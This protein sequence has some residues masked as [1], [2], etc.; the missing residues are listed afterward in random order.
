[1]VFCLALSVPRSYGQVAFSPVPLAFPQ[2]VI[3]GDPTGVNYTTLIQMI[4][5]NSATVTGKLSLLSDSGSALQGSFDGQSPQTS[6]DISLG[7]SEFRQIAVTLEGGVTVGWLAAAFSPAEVVTS[8]ILQ[9]RSG[10]SLLSEVGVDPAY[11]TVLNTDFA[12]DTDDGLNTGVALANPSTSPTYI[13]ARLWDPATGTAGASTIIALAGNGHIARFV[14]E[15]FPDALNITKTR[16]KVSLDGCSSASCT[17]GGG[18]GFIAT[19]IRINGDQFT[20][21][22]VAPRVSGGPTTRILP[23]VAFGGASSGLNMK[24]VLYLTTNVSTGVFGTA[25]IFNDDGTPL[26]ASIDGASPA[27]SFPFT[28]PGNRVTRIALSGDETLRGGWLRLTLPGQAHLVA[29]ALFQTFEG[30]TLV[31]EASVL[32]TPVMTRGL[33]PL[34]IQPGTDIGLALA[35]PQT[36]SNTATITLHDLSGTAVAT[37]EITLP[38]SG[39]LAKFVTEIFAAQFKDLPLFDGAVSIR[40]TSALAPLALRLGSGKIA[41]LPVTEDGFHRPSIT[42]MGI[43]RTQRSPAQVDFSIDV[44]DVDSDVAKSGASSVAVDAYIDF[45]SVND[46]LTVT[47]DGTAMIDRTTATLTGIFRPRITGI[48]AN[49]PATLYLQVYDTQ[50]NVSNLIAASFRF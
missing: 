14:T 39:H 9:Y 18:N 20:T 17:F 31:S 42:S 45:G 1:M 13:L 27:T 6:L 23:Q 3:G 7:P 32:D 37:S 28:V 30:T 38:P 21:V 16:A 47:L 35:N 29:N 44:R 46:F 15:I 4:N 10:A 34:R 50:G 36:E 33:I 48:Q 19:A 11:S 2:I 5:N 12:I 25:E 49:T 41:T 26:L 43:S 8:V 40:S 24:T 22:P